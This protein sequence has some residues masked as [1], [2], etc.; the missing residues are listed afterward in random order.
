MVNCII[1]NCK[2]VKHLKINWN[3][4]TSGVFKGFYKDK[5]TKIGTFGG[6]GRNALSRILKTIELPE[7]VFSN[8]NSKVE[9]YQK[10][11]VDLS[12]KLK[13]ITIILKFNNIH[14]RY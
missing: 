1:V 6:A 9:L 10:N 5:D 13:N 14:K 12:K 7:P 8:F 2:A 11:A 4:N 3:K